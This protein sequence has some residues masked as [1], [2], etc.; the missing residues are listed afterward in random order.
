VSPSGGPSRVRPKADTTDYTVLKKAL[1]ADEQRQYHVK[2][3]MMTM[4]RTAFG[5]MRRATRLRLTTGDGAH[6]HDERFRPAH[7]PHRDE[8]DRATP[9][10][11]SA[12]DSSSVHL[13]DLGVAENPEGGQHENADSRA[14][15]PPVKRDQKLKDNRARQPAPWPGAPRR[16]SVSAAQVPAP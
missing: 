15:I 6:R 10:M 16:R 1:A 12:T 8:I 4:R 11:K 9:L 5:P 14:E 7:H 13:V 3:T 2:P